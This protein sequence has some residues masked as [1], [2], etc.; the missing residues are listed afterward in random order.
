MQ[1][2]KEIRLSQNFQPIAV[3]PPQKI[4]YRPRCFQSNKPGHETRNSRKSRQTLEPSSFSH[5]YRTKPRESGCCAQSVN[6]VLQENMQVRLPAPLPPRAPSV[7]AS[8]ILFHQNYR[9]EHVAR[10]AVK[11]P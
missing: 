11:E 3:P 4:L 9:F 6:T 5:G 2:S 8:I 1:L 7:F 10:N